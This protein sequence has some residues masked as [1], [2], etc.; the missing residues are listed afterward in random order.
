MAVVTPDGIVGKVLA[1]YPT[2]SQVLLITDPTF[3]AGV[4]SEKN[5]VHGTS[6][7]S[8]RASASSTTCK[9]RRKW[10]WARCSILRET[11]ACSRKA[12]PIGTA[13]V[14]RAGKTFKEIYIVPSGTQNGL[15][16]VLVVIEGVHQAIP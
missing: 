3:A 8:A 9:T 13:T 5:R 2:A 12:C 15:E 14:V 1:S 7:E 6:R 16:E 4:I 11:T 10:M